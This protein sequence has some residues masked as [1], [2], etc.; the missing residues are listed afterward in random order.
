MPCT[1]RSPR[2]NEV[3]GVDYRFLTKEEFEDLEKKGLLVEAGLYEGNFYGT[4]RPPKTPPDSPLIEN[5]RD[6]GQ[7]PVEQ[8]GKANIGNLPN[9]WEIARTE[10]GTVTYTKIY[11]FNSGT[12]EIFS[13][14]ERI[15]LISMSSD[16]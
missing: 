7:A 5:W 11:S 1:T 13:T 10:S 15:L 6:P 2:E 3:D 4:P 12:H 16:I 9:G 14:L 8:N